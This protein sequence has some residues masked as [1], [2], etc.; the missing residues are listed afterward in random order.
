MITPMKK[1]NALGQTVNIAK[2]QREREKNYK[3]SD[4]KNRYLRY[5]KIRLQVTTY[6]LEDRS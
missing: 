3:V 4:L 6:N 1:E 2:Q 5:M